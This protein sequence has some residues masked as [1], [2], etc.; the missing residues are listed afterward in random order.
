[1]TESGTI[2]VERAADLHDDALRLLMADQE[3][4]DAEFAAI[5]TVSGFGGR[6][7]V[8]V[9]TPPLPR[10]A[11]HPRE[12]ERIVPATALA[13]AVQRDRRVRSPPGRR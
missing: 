9:V 11:R 12:R 6:K 5:M 8:A 3:W 1:M 10:L 4:V 7:V 2:T 13:P